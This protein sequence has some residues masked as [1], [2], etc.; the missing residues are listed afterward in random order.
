[1]E[2]DVDQV[3]L[4][5]IG[6][7]QP[8]TYSIGSGRKYSVFMTTNRDPARMNAAAQAVREGGY[9]VVE[10][11]TRMQEGLRGTAIFYQKHAAE[12]AADIARRIDAA[13]G[14]KPKVEPVAEEFASEID[15]VVR[16]GQ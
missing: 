9:D 8:L 4:Y 10:L 7:P 5:R 1:V 14:V 2:S 16:F 3:E 11:S 15:V 6:Q 13:V 12:A